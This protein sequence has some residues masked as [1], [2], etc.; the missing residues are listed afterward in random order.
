MEQKQNQQQ[1]QRAPNNQVHNQVHLAMCATATLPVQPERI[2]FIIDS[3]AAKSVI[4]HDVPL[5]DE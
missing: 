3:G 2:E 5:L 4:C 1:Q